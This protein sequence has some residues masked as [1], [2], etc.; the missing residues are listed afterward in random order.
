MFILDV[1]CMWLLQEV[2]LLP[3]IKAITRNKGP[4]AIT[5]GNDYCMR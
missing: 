1:C 5:R 3:E 2:K 4:K